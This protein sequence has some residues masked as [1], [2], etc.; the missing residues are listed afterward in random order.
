M[1]KNLLLFAIVFLQFMV[2]GQNKPDSIYLIP[3]V[4]ASFVGGDSARVLFVKNNLKINNLPAENSKST[5]YV[6]F[7]VEK[8]GVLSDVK[9]IKGINQT[10][11][12]EVL[13]MTKTM[14]NWNPAQLD[15]QTVRS[16]V[17]FPIRINSNVSEVVIDTTF[18]NKKWKRTV[19]DSAAYYRIRK[20]NGPKFKI[21]YYL[22]NGTLIE[23]GEY[24]SISPE[25]KNG[26]FIAYFDN[27]VKS[28]ESNYINDTL[29]GEAFDFYPNGA[30]KKK[31]FFENNT[32]SGDMLTYS[33]RGE[34]RSTE[35]F[36]NN[37]LHG[38]SVYIVNGNDSGFVEREYSNGILINSVAKLYTK[39]KEVQKGVDKQDSTVVFSDPEFPGGDE[40][41]MVFLKNNLHYPVEARENGISGTV[42]AQFEVEIDGSILNPI[43]TRD[44]GGGCG[45]EVLR[46][47]KLMP[48]WIPGKQSGKQVMTQFTLPVMFVLN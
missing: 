2:N 22:I 31:M 44:I 42:Y 20:M 48:R 1:K 26:S 37:L 4:E 39:K 5:I 7:V 47:I 36:K 13:R 28:S 41:R 40:A 38:V 46:I 15:G 12:E 9:I 35:K 18:L 10:I 43:I 14:P 34:L 45:E 16:Q 3:T 21:Q 19:V 8:S 29:Q 32:I 6:Q 33:S 25:K 27:G 23:Q 17:V 30:V 11:D 24:S